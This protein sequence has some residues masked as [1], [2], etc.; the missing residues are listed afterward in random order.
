M[1]AADRLY[2]AGRV[3]FKVIPLVGVCILGWA[4]LDLFLRP[5]SPAWL[6]LAALTV[7]TGSFTVKIPGLV[8]RLSVSEPF[9]FAA[10]LW[11]G[12]SVGAVTAALDALIMSLWLL[13]T[14]KTFYRVA[15]NVSVLVIS[16]WV[17]SQ[18]F[19]YLAQIDPRAPVYNSL[20]QFVLPAVSIH[21]LFISL[22]QRSGR[23]RAIV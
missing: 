12:P 14:L 3:Y 5:P 16:I 9:V 18:G 17:A 11:F 23:R 7:L 10:T 13:P 20:E 22:E 21:S 19:F 6:A 4:L 2:R 1:I 8:A 15:F